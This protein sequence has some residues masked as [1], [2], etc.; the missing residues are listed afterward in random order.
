MS[1]RLK[2]PDG[3]LFKLPDGRFLLIAGLG[4]SLAPN[5]ARAARLM[6]AVRAFLEPP[7][8]PAAQPGGRPRLVPPARPAAQPGVRPKIRS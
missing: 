8:L 1:V 7:A 5:L 2:L 3:R 6:A 4:V